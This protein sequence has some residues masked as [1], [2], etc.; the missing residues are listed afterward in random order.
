MLY[1]CA[2]TLAL[3]L[4][5][6]YPGDEARFIET[7]K[8][9]GRALSLDLLRSYPEMSGPLPF[10]FYGWWGRVF[11]YSLAAMRCGS[12]ALALAA[13]LILWIFLRRLLD[14]RAAFLSGCAL[15]LNPYFATMSLFVYTD[16]AAVGSGLAALATALH[17]RPV[18]MAMALAAAMLSR[19][20]MVFLALGLGVFYW[21]QTRMVAACAAS[22]L[23]LA[24]LVVLWG[25]P[26]PDSWM[27]R[28][29]LAGGTHFQMASLTG[30]IAQMPI[31]LL[32]FVIAAR[33]RLRFPAPVMAAVLVASGLYWL[34]PIRVPDA[35]AR[36][37]LSTVGLLDRALT[38]AGI[39]RDA[40]YWAGFFTGL[41]MLAALFDD[42]RRHRGY[43]L[44]A[45]LVTAAFLAVMPWSYLY[46]E[47]Y[48]LPLLPV[49][50][51]YLAQV[52]RGRI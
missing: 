52:A 11:G 24:A 28:E 34:Y 23:P 37:G 26:A 40:V 6:P 35:S 36:I 32:P 18:T 33:R 39:W 9:F 10:L 38:Q 4:S 46:W 16:M 25:G 50:A 13:L 3:G 31:Y 51:A 45:A 47:K 8:L 29:Y 27:R 20:Y 48:L 41:L 21:R 49:A 17:G 2:V 14:E 7:A 12:L 44:L 42:A 1:L 43:P 5:T 22:M 19:Q 15:C 30:Y